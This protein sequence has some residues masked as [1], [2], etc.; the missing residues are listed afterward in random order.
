ME[1][2]RKRSERAGEEEEEER[3]RGLEV[4]EGEVKPL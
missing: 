3:R 4:S 1:V 2:E